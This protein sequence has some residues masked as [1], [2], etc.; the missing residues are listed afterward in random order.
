M[1][2]FNPYASPAARSVVVTA[3]GPSGYR[4]YL[5][6]NLLYAALVGVFLLV[7][8]V[9]GNIR[10][11]VPD[12]LVVGIFIAPLLSC[13]MVVANYAR[14]FRYWRFVQALIAGV[15]L[16]FC[17][18]DLSRSALVG[19]GL[20]MTLVNSLSLIT[21]SHFYLL[22]HAAMQPAGVVQKG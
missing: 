2:E 6:L 16:L 1:D 13:W 3:S 11:A 10:L 7:L 21:S 9:G 8:L 18:E 15:L 12:V 22:K 17:L 20:F 19:V 5:V 14:V 4:L